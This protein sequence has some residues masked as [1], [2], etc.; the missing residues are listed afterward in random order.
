MKELWRQIGEKIILPKTFIEFIE[1]A[2]EINCRLGTNADFVR[3][4]ECDGRLR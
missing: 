4:F 2:D 1:I 3:F